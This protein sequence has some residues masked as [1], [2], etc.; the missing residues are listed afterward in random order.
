MTCV[1]WKLFLVLAGFAGALAAAPAEETVRLWE[2]FAPGYQY[3]VS[4][5]TELSGSLTLPPGKDQAK[6]Q[7]LAVTG[8]SSIEY[9]ERVLDLAKDGRVQKTVRIYRRLDFQRKVGDRTQA[10][11]LR[12]EARRLVLL[13][14]SGSGRE[15]RPQ[16]GETRPELEPRP[17]LGVPFCPDGP[18]TWGE[19]DLVRT[20]VFTP[21]LAGLLPE[22]AVA[23]G[24]RWTAADAALQELTG[25][26]RI[27]EGKVACRLEQ[28]TV[29]ERRRHARIALAGTVRGVNEDGPN[30]QQLDG[31]FYF[32]L[33]SHHLSYLYLKGV[34][35]LLDKDGKALGRVEGQFVLTR[36]APQPSRDLSDEA[37]KGVALVPNA[38]N[39]LL[40]FDRPE[41]GLRFLYPRRWRV[42][43]AEGRQVTVDEANGSGL[44][45]TLEPAARTP[46]GAQFLAEVHDW[47]QRQQAKVL[48]VDQP[49]RQAGP[50]QELEHFTCDVEMGGQRVVLDYYVARQAA[51]GVTL[52]ARLLPAEAAALQ[53]DVAGLAR[54][55]K[56][57]RT[58]AEPAKAR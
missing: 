36:Q 16:P 14:S 55:L 18:L 51:G 28:L 31:Y 11:N 22:G 45:L 47:L 54:S 13:R 1:G 5:R 52:A 33:E 53:G 58:I 2:D 49:K 50:P 40:L 46:T 34:S 15:T 30:R 21:A 9:D 10:T 24:S 17:Q 56:V 29:L 26:E 35:F 3:H 6:P 48:R 37:L 43:V 19:I 27:E 8:S 20:D 41:I 7:A 57:T 42:G 38:N 32:D 4:T 44:L 23:V 39:T 25:L 12:P